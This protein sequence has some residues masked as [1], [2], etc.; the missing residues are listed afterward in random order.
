MTGYS[1]DA[2]KYRGRMIIPSIYGLE[3]TVKAL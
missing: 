1:I 3:I 2:G